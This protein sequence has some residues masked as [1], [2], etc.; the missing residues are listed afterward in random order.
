MADAIVQGH[1]K[2]STR[3]RL[4]QI[5]LKLFLRLVKYFV[6]NLNLIEVIST[7]CLNE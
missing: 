3:G 5:L 1:S 7:F 6:R 4:S 2:Y